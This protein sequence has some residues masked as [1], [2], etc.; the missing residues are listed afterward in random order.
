MSIFVIDQHKGLLALVTIGGFIVA[1]IAA[2]L[3]DI[4]MSV[5]RRLRRERSA[6][7]PW[8]EIRTWVEE[9]D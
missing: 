2:A 3:N 4:S 8:H 7:A 5:E 9:D 6:G 1:V